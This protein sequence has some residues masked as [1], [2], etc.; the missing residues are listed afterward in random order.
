VILGIGT[1]LVEVSRVSHSI[2]NYGSKFTERVFTAGER[3]YAESKANSAERFAARFAAK[4]AAMK[5]L[6]TGWSSGVSWTQIEV[7]NDADG[8]PQL[9]LHEVAAELARKMGVRR[10]WLSLTHIGFMACAFVIFEGAAD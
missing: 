4:E 6:G 1:D 9:V 5:A 2:S 8:R 7:I 10:I 3:A